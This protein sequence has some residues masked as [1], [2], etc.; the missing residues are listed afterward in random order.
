MVLL[1]AAAITAAAAG[2]YKGGETAV[3]GAKQKVRD[4]KLDRKRNGEI[5]VR[6]KER[7]ERLASITKKRE[8][9]AAFRRG[10]PT[11]KAVSAKVES[12]G[13]V[14]SSGRFLMKK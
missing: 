14:L 1:T 11:A 13:S 3:K 12:V 2:V 4:I 6:S 7:K 8:D 5:A 9:G 10:M